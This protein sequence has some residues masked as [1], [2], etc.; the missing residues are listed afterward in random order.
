MRNWKVAVGVVVS[1]I[2]LGLALAGIE[3]IRA[4]EALQRADW[5]YFLPAGISLLGNLLAR[6]ARWRVLLG[7]RVGLGKAFS[8]TN[9]GYL[10]SNVL[11]FRLG[12][13]ARAVAIGLDGSAK[14][15]TALSTVLVERVLDM[16]T[17]VVLLALT[18]PFVGDTGWTQEAG[19]LG[20]AM[21]L[22]AMG[23]LILLATRPRWGRGWLDR[24]LMCLPW[25]DRDRWRESFDGLLEGLAVLRSPGRTVAVIGWSAITWSL[26]VGYYLATLRAF[27]ERPSLVEASFLTCA[28]ALGVALPSSPGAM[29]VFHSV[30]RYA[31][32]LPFG[33]KAE[34]AVAIAFASHA[35]QYVVMC[36]LG[37]VGLVHQNLSFAQL[38]DE[39]SEAATAVEDRVGPGDR[40]ASH[41]RNVQSTGASVELSLLR[42]E[43]KEP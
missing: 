34:T 23:L 32:E 13:P 4:R 21:G 3:W 10:I 33:L 2:C 26:T 35:L 12:D 28:T 1:L 29:G 41:A 20:A 25:I 11:P 15:S 16:L 39:A 27:I 24:V 19:L 7:S 40:V 42:K 22:V 30:A 31:L 14:I 6:S 43:S 37:L 36:L 5:R 8:V 18:V 17:V 38:R 9:I